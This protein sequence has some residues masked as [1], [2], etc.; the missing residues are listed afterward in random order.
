[1]PPSFA[2]LA[3][4]ACLPSASAAGLRSKYGLNNRSAAQVTEDV[5]NS[6]QIGMSQESPPQPYSALAF[7]SPDRQVVQQSLMDDNQLAESEAIASQGDEVLVF[8]VLLC[9]ARCI[10]AT[11]SASTHAITQQ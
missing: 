4:I 1:M 10:S 3:L 9:N 8:G 11:G 7:S 6:D 2:G 5:L